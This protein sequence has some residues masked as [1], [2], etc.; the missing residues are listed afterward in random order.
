V[1]D[2]VPP[3]GFAVVLDPDRLG[4]L[5]GARCVD[6][7]QVGQR[8]VV[9]TDRLS[10]REEP[11]PLQPIYA[12]GS[13]LIGVHLPKPD[14]H[15]RVGRNPPVDMRE[16]KPRIPCIIVQIDESRSPDSASPR[17]YSST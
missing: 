2:A 17:M 10:H 6:A 16:P 8:A 15:R 5:G 7:E 12:L 14:V 3:T 13:G 4:R 11:D 9:H 1:Q